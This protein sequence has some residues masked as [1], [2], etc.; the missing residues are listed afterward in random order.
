MH[1]LGITQNIVAIAEQTAR[2]HGAA[3]VRSVVVEI[4][5]LSGVSADAV[6]F[7]FEACSQGTLL[8]GT[9]LEIREI[10]GRARCR[11][12]LVESPVDRQTYACPL[13]GAW[14]L[15]LLQGEELKILELEVD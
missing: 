15:E 8:E 11:G 2:E 6:D 14:D 9:R 5:K 13:C 10:S 12:C 7:C 4:G 3:R 1:E